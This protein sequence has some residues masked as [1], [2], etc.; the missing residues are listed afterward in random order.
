MTKQQLLELCRSR[1]KT[2]ILLVLLILVNVGLAVYEH[3]VQEPRIVRLEQEWAA[4]RSRSAGGRGDIS[5]IYRQGLADLAQFRERAPLKRDFTRLIM[6]IFEM[7]SN[8]GLKVV[9][10]AYKP[11]ASKD[12]DLLINGITL[13]LS[14]RYAGIKSFVSDLQC[15]HTLMTV[16]SFQ[17]ASGSVTEETLSLKLDLSLYLRAEAR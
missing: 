15:Q 9:S 4:K 12:G 7:A 10:I 3:T 14:G 6:E 8:N 2:L 17:I 11:A 13:N 5:E 16:D 1:P